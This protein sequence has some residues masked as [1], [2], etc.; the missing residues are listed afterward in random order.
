M[1]Q[2][3]SELDKIAEGDLNKTTDSDNLDTSF[4]R[5]AT[6]A[7][8]EKQVTDDLQKTNTAAAGNT[9]EEPEK[10]KVQIEQTRNQMSET[11]DAIQEKLSFSNISEQVSEQVNNAVSTAKD[12]V[13]DATIGRVENIMQNVGE[14][15]SNV[16]E[17]MGDA[18]SYV[19]R[20][21]KQNPLPLALIGL[22]VGL[23]LIQGKRSKSKHSYET[24][25]HRENNKY[26][27][28][29]RNNPTMLKKAT[30]AGSGIID[31]VQKTVSNVAGSGYDAVSNAA[32]SAYQGVESL[33]SS[34][35]DQVQHIT[36]R[37]Q[38][39]YARTLEENPLAIGAIA[40]AVGAVVGLSIPSTEYEN[41][42][43]GETKEN[44]VQSVGEVARDTISKA[45]DVAG[46]VTKT[47]REQVKDQS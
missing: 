10:I 41:Q 7:E 3:P 13:Y 24:D 4:E 5:S 27:G 46:E 6:A 2:R 14:R 39:Q 9:S 44:L 11:I 23:L 16:S 33:A 20:T 12:A 42:W 30:A 31:S 38:T 21:A 8:S 43:M 1:D 35:S 22:G 28:H 17:T 25:R 18:G 45:Q 40:L 37:A 26:V 19:V 47:V 32:S 15:L 29:E 36:R 34:T